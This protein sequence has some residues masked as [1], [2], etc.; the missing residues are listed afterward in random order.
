MQYVRELE[1]VM[2]YLPDELLNPKYIFGDRH[3]FWAVVFSQ[4]PDWANEYH[5]QVMEHHH[6][7]P[8]VNPKSRMIKITDDWL[9]LLQDFDYKTKG[10][11]PKINVF[12]QRKESRR[13]Q[14][15]DKPSFAF[16]T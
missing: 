11:N 16:N 13:S 7:L 1:G 2:D 15:I 10:K 5:H 3:F 4:H 14:V 6:A 9:K 8:K 12:N